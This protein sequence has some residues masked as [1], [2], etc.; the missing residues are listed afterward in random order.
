ME[1]DPARIAKIRKLFNRI[2]DDQSGT[3][4]AAEIGRLAA[5]IDVELEPGDISK[6][7]VELDQD[8][9]GQADFEEF[10]ILSKNPF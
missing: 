4:E 2:Y 9:S 5:L 10:V 3:I 7:A 1:G 6:A 8:G